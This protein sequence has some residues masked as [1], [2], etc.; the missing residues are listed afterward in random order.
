MV[1][2]QTTIEQCDR[3]QPEPAVQDRI[4]RRLWEQNGRRGGGDQPHKRNQQAYVTEDQDDDDDYI[5]DE[6]E[7]AKPT[8]RR[9]KRPLRDPPEAQ[10][11]REREGH[12]REAK[13]DER[14]MAVKAR[15]YCS[16]CKKRARWHRDAECWLNEGKNS[17]GEHVH[18]GLLNTDTLYGITNCACAHTVGRDWFKK[19][20]K[21]AAEYGVPHFIISLLQ[22]PYRSSAANILRK[23][24]RGFQKHYV[25]R[26]E[27]Q[28]IHV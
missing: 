28:H 4:N 20:V 23:Q 26:M 21:R 13:T 11:D 25:D 2:R 1:H 6:V 10:A 5:E 16:A 3:A 9:R 15:S 8:P 24:E 17:G 19:T 12:H 14:I 18:G 7:G 27:Q 22:Q